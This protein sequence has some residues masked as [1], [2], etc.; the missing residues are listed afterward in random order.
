MKKLHRSTLALALLM[1]AACVASGHPL[2]QSELNDISSHEDTIANA[3]ENNERLFE[4]ID[5]LGWM[6]EEE[7]QK[8]WPDWPQI[9]A[10]NFGILLAN[11]FVGENNEDKIDAVEAIN[12]IYDSHGHT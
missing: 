2:S 4:E 7:Y 6:I 3:T 5:E 8:E 11:I 9:F 12:D 1:V 10:W